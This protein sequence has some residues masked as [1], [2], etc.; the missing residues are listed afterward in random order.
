MVGHRIRKRRRRAPPRQL[1][2]RAPA[3]GRGGFRERAGRPKKD[4]AIRR[5]GRY[6]FDRRMPVHV[7]MRV[8]PHVYNLR[9]RRCFVAL[10]TAF[11]AGGDRY[12]MRLTGFSVQGNHIH[13][14]VEANDTLALTRGM[15]AL[16]IRI[17][18]K[19]NNVMARHGAV[20]AER[21]H[22]H[23]LRT[24]NETANAIRYVRENA[25][26]PGEARGD[27]YSIG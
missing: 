3:T 5:I 19:L 7:T 6:K 26:Q 13:M 14:L 17:A 27:T 16:N 22:A 23:V 2:L 21:F 20:L 10:R 1:V 18:R 12:G 25:R 24:P 8:L 11:L 15:H 4:G 9:S